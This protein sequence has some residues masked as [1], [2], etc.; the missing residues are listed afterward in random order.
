MHIGIV[1]TGIICDYY[2]ENLINQYKNCDYTKI[3]STWDYTDTDIIDKL[4][5]N[6]FFVILSKFPSNIYPSS[7]NYQNYSAVMG[8]R[9]AEKLNV[10]HVIRL[11]ADMYCNNITNLL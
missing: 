7:I 4:L 3:V 11:R 1:I 9:C 5:N 6:G 10:T 8:I 2:L